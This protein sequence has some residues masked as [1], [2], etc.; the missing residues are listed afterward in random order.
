LY[1]KTD[2]KKADA[3]TVCRITPEK[4]GNYAVRGIN[5]ERSKQE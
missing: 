5:E 2:G 1:G 4:T 3:E